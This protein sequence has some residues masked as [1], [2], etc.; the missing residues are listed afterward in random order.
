MVGD[1]NIQEPD[2]DPGYRFVPAVRVRRLPGVSARPGTATRSDCCTRTRPNT[3]GSAA[4]GDGYR[5]DHALVS[6]GLADRLTACAYVHQT[7]TP[8]SGT[9]LT[10]PSALTLDLTGQIPPVRVD[11]PESAPPPDA[12]F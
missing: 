2:H 1:L 12:L 7:R 8:D 3:P 5:Y 6:P 9:R 10:D 4:P 11:D